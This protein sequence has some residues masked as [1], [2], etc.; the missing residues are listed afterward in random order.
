MDFNMTMDTKKK[1]KKK[2]IILI[3]LIIILTL[4]LAAVSIYYFF[5][6]NKEKPKPK[7]KEPEVV[8]KL[9][10]V[11][12]D[13]NARPIAVMID[14][15]VGDSLHKGLQDAYITYEAIVEGSLSRI[16]VVYKDK[17]V[18]KIGPVRSSRHYFLD[19]ALES[20]CIYAHF[21][22]SPYAKSDISKLGVNNINGLYDSYPF[23]RVSD[24]YAPHNV[25]T[26][27]EKLYK[28]AEKLGYKT[29]TEDWKL[30]NYNVDD[31][32]LDKMYKDDPNLKEVSDISFS[33]MSGEKRS[34]TYDKNN[35]YYLRFM[36]GN[37]HKDAE[38]KQQYHYK[39][40]IFIKVSNA[41]LDAKRWDLNTTGTGEGYY[42]TNG[43]MIPITWQKDSR[44]SKSKYLYNGQEIEINDGNTFIEVVPKNKKIKYTEVPKTTTDSTT[45]NTNTN[46]KT[47]R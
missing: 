31:V 21:G 43:Y 12:E 23:K 8:K 37:P 26:S 11:N 13:S 2:K 5:F 40:L 29:E 3:V 38:T 24:Y 28:Y 7:P 39:N 42:L 27:T 33:Y 46:N 32:N 47:E 6:L 4:L 20:D 35:K 36:H 44:S 10:I 19:Y 25:F 17:D 45:N 34:F 9:Q 15:N 14:N 16:M 41:L 22:W 1:T 30:L 18:K